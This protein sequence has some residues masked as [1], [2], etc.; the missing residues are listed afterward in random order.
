MLAAPRAFAATQP[1]GIPWHPGY[2]D[3][4]PTVG[5][6]RFFTPEEAAAVD[7]MTARLIP[8]DA[9]GPG[10]REAGVTGF[11]DRQLAGF[12][13]RGQRWY[14]RGPFRDG[15]AEQ[16]YQSS[17]PPAQLYRRALAALDR[18]CRERHGGEPFANLAES[19]QDEL[20]KAL[21]D[22][23]LDLGQV[24]GKTFFTLLLDNAIEG[25]FGD[26]IYGGNRDM[27]GWRLVGFPGARYDYRPFIHHDGAR[28]SLEPV[29]LQGRPGWNS[30]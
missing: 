25:F 2:A 9:L 20:L 17:L 5:D 3:L 24:S 23:E 1:K 28:I 15:T 10:A 4:P 13:G 19:V 27:V 14:M 18:H 29:S 22:G 26:P 12:Y 8:A 6:A 11:I 30:R 7:A 21:E 16:G